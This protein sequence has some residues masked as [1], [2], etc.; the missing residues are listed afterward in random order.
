MMMGLGE[1]QDEVVEVF[2]DLRKVGVSILTL[3]QYLRPSDK[4]AVMTRYY[5]PDEFRE[6]KR[7]ALGLGFVHVE[8]GPLVRSSYHAHEQADAAQ[9]ALAS[10]G[11]PGAQDTSRLSSD[12]ED[13]QHLTHLW[14]LIAPRLSSSL[15]VSGYGCVRCTGPFATSIV[16]WPERLIFFTSAPF[17]D[18]V[19]DHL[20]VAARRGVCTAVLPS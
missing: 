11:L 14:L 10:P 16:V 1:E 20:G 12:L 7:I 8:A 17:D 18:Q 3:G 15:I 5:H 6:L 19:T 9:A 2:K 13:A 4:H